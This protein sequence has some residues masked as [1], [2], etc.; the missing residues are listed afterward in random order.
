MFDK[1]QQID[2]GTHVANWKRS[3]KREG[4]A[5][6]QK[7]KHGK[8]WRAMTVPILKGHNTYRKREREYS[9]R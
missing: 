9:L 6:S 2:S 4:I 8:I 3:H 7:K 1:F 5:E